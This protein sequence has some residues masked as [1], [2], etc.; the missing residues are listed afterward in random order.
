M[1]F[2]EEGARARAQVVTAFRETIAFVPA[3]VLVGGGF[4]RPAQELS[5][6][7]LAGSVA[8]EG[9]VA[10]YDPEP[11]VD[12]IGVLEADADAAHNLSRMIGE[13][14][15]I[16]DALVA[17]RERGGRG[18]ERRRRHYEGKCN[19]DPFHGLGPPR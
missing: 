11:Q 12:P 6:F 8:F 1:S 3:H 18:G 13:M 15:R 9:G 7:G 17:A 2:D 4:R 16:I 19:A 10:L 14:L 5:T